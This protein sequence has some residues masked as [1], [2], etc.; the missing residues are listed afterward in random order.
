MELNNELSFCTKIDDN[1]ITNESIDLLSV[2]NDEIVIYDYKSDVAEFIIDDIFEQTLI[3][4]YKNQL[5]DYEKEVKAL[6]K[7]LSIIKKIIYFRRYNKD[8][9]SV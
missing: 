1:E 7:D 5:D 9:K 3:E 4:K 6:Y 2:S 8:N